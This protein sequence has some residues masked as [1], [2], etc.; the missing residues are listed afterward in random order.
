MLDLYMGFDTR[1]STALHMPFQ[2]PPYLVPGLIQVSL[3][4]RKE[5]SL[6]TN[7]SYDTTCKGTQTT[8]AKK[9]LRV[10]EEKKIQENNI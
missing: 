3:N 7:I 2:I 4:S 9:N 5:F 10:N 6:H 8:K 1:K